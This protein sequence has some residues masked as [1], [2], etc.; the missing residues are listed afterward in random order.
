MTSTHASSHAPLSS[1]PGGI[2]RAA[3]PLDDTAQPP[4]TSGFGALME[5]EKDI[6]LSTLG[7]VGARGADGAAID[8][9]LQQQAKLLA[10][11]VALLEQRYEMLPHAARFQ[12]LHEIHEPLSHRRPNHTGSEIGTLPTLRAL[13]LNALRK[14]ETLVHQRPDGQ[15]GELILAHIAHNH[16]EMAGALSVLLKDEASAGPNPNAAIISAARAPGLSVGEAGWENEGGAQP[17]ASALKP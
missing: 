13:H 1:P 2:T 12:H 10:A 14:L 3:A 11:N 5:Q 6:Q 4:L 15:R 9:L 17:A 16:E 7:H 8:H